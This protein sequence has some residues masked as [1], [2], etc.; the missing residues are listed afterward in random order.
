MRP[1]LQVLIGTPLALALA[2]FAQPAAASPSTQDNLT[3]HRDNARTGWYRHETALTASNVNAASFGQIGVLS[4]VGKVYAQPLYVSGENVRGRVRDLVIVASATDQLYAY[5]G[6]TLAPVWHRSFISPPA[7]R[8]QLWNDFGGGKASCGDVSPDIGITGTPVVDRALDRLFV[9]VPTKEGN[10]FHMRLHAVSLKTG[11]DVVAPVEVAATSGTQRVDPLG[12]FQRAGLL[13]SGGAVYVALAS[14]CDMQTSVTH[15]WLISYRAT[16]LQQ[17]GNLL[18]VTKLAVSTSPSPPPYYLGSPWMAG[19]GP[20]ADALGNVYFATGNGAF[21]GKTSFAM[22]VLKVPA[23]LDLTKATSFTP[24]TWQ[25]DNANDSDLGSGGV[26]L[27]P[28]QP[29]RF[30]HLLVQGGKCTSA[31]PC[32]KYLLNRD[33]LGGVQPS[34][35]GPSS[36]APALWQA[37][38]AGP[39]WGGPAYFADA[40]GAQYVLYGGGMPPI[41]A[42]LS[43]YRLT[44]AP[45]VA[46]TLVK[47]ASYPNRCLE[48]RSGGSQPVVSSN[49]TAPGTAV[50]WVVQ[51]PTSAGGAI[52]LLAFDAASMSTLF[53]APA[54]DWT[55]ATPPPRPFWQGGAMV[56]PLVANGRVYVPAQDTVTVFGLKSAAAA[57]G[58][59]THRFAIAAAPAAAPP[60]GQPPH[61]IAGTIVAV[62]GTQLTLHPRTGPDVTVD[63]SAAIANGTYSAPLF[64]G[65]IVVVQGTRAANGTF[66]AVSV[67]RVDA[68]KGISPDY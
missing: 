39:M 22:S 48:C 60:T 37:D 36:P 24:A 45:S 63:A 17:I 10:A 28:D 3:F 1:L 49:G 8:Q 53:S 41:T 52:G 57:A 61:A 11:G 35:A 42:P 26:M 5:D 13:E 32:Y 12:N 34:S 64:K 31:G 4:V 30:P 62:K 40:R 46:L 55:K 44:T 6:A 18:N 19:F 27:L 33:K 20:A 25:A 16:T 68:L 51:T 29:G 38:T 50:V 54:G 14:H 65:K 58:A 23:S 47:S 21:D 15:G 7:S 67:T 43:T 59:P 9:V 2:A 66:R 56:S